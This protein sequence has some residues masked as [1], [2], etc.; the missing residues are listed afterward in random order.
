VV[1]GGDPI[2]LLHGQPGSARDWELVIE[3]IGDRAQAIP[4]KRPG[5]AGPGAPMD[6]QGNARA[7][8]AT[9]DVHGL[10]RATIVGHSLGGTIAAW[11][12]AEHPERVGGLALVAPAANVASLNR[13]DRLLATRVA[14][15]LLST[16]G[17]AGIGAALA[18]GPL[19]ERIGAK[20]GLRDGYLRASSRALLSPLVWR[21]FAVEQRAL[22]AELPALEARLPEIAAPTT[23]V[24]GTA[25][26]IVPPSSARQLAERIRDAELVEIARASHLLPQ[27]Q[28]RRLAEVIL[29]AVRRGRTRSS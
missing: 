9:L 11:L 3:A 15:P 13:I 24:I 2:L 29:E 10:E 25:D 19:R 17:L 7:A 4:I 23:I 21:S 8:L 14:G 6:L 1:T 27:Q 18:V 5:W 28:P 16:A 12:A 22:I 20:L 26:R